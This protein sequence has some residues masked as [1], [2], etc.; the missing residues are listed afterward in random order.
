MPDTKSFG[1]ALDAREEAP[2]KPADELGADR[3]YHAAAPSETMAKIKPVAIPTRAGIAPV[4]SH[5]KCDH[6]R[7][8]C[9]RY[10]GFEG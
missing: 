9:S 3:A 2:A 8:T 5:L 1:Q 7:P 6:P 10:W 4:I